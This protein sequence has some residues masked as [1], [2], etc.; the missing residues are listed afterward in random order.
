MPRFGVE[1]YETDSGRSPVPDFLNALE[2]KK[3][4]AWT[5]CMYYIELLQNE[6]HQL[7][8]KHQYA[9]KVEDGVYCLRPAWN[10]VEYRLFYTWDGK[11]FVLV[12]AIVKKTEQLTERDKKRVRARVKEVLNG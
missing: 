8:M 4:K 12:D 7:L 5:K 9:E 3:P 1:Y 10:N 6:G 2:R 11:A